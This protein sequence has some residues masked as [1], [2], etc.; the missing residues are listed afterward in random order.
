MFFDA[1]IAIWKIVSNNL[2]EA[3]YMQVEQCIYQKY[4]NNKFDTKIIND[5]EGSLTGDDDC[6]DP[7]S[8]DNVPNLG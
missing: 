4:I 2:F 7:L 6:H 8:N 3:K 5:S 1:D